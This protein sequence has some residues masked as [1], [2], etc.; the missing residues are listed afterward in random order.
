[1]GLAVQGITRLSGRVLFMGNIRGTLE[2]KEKEVSGILRK[3][4]KILGTWNS[5]VTPRGNNEWTTVLKYMDRE[6][7]VAPLISHILPLSAGP[8]IFRKIVKREEF[9]N[10]VIFDLRREVK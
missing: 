9:T 10:K 6:M 7:N 2:L 3:E 8:E 5:K 1:M 4:I